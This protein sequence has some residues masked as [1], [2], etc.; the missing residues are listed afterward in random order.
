MPPQHIQG[1]QGIPHPQVPGEK[2][3]KV[4]KEIAE[5]TTTGS[6]SE[7]AFSVGGRVRD[8]SLKEII[9]KQLKVEVNHLEG[10]G[11]VCTK[12]GRIKSKAVKKEKTPE[13]LMLQ[14]LRGLASRLL[15][16]SQTPCVPMIWR[17]KK[18]VTGI[19]SAIGEMVQLDIRNSHELASWLV[20]L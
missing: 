3:Y 18:M 7:L 19:P 15:G 4:L 20:G 1:Q 10:Q 11:Q 5:N 6:R 16:M 14:D 13:Q 9:A 17:L 2:M 8:G 12:T